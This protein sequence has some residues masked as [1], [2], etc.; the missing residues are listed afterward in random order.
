MVAGEGIGMAAVGKWVGT[1][2]V[3]SVAGWLM[4]GKRVG[5]G[6]LVA[7]T[8]VDR[9]AGIVAFAKVAGAAWLHLL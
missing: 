6:S 7:G 2:A 3:G 9:L 4:V 8:V 5:T 1:A